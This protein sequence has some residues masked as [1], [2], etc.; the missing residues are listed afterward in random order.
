MGMKYQ[1]KSEQ[2]AQNM[3]AMSTKGQLQKQAMLMSVKDLAGWTVWGC[4]I[5]F[6]IT[7]L[8]PYR[9]RDISHDKEKYG[10]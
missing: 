1:G 4:I 7:I 9:K 5:A 2:E 8:I 6:F 3:A 10:I